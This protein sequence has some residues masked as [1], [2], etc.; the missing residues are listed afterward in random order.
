VATAERAAAPDAFRHEA[1]F[2]AGDDEYLDLAVPFLRE[3]VAREEPVLVVVLAPK[4]GLLRDALGDDAD[5]VTFADMADVGANP[6]RIIPAWRTFVAAHQGRPARGIGEPIFPARG[7]EEL[8]E[9][10]RHEALLNLAFAGA[11]GFELVCPYDTALLPPD[12]VEEALR[13]HPYVHAAGTSP[14]YRDGLLDQPLGPPPAGAARLDYGDGPLDVVHRFVTAYASN[15]GLSP[16]RA[17]D[18]SIAAHELAINTIRHAG[19]RGSVAVWVEGGYV[20]CEVRDDGVI[21][22][23]LVGRALPPVEQESGRGMWMVNQLCDLVQLRSS[24]AGTTVRVRM[25]LA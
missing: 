8:V 5:G 16:S 24:A 23:P 12:V 11:D 1:L 2:Y 18:L 10:Q 15:A 25:A 22:D 17:I 20:V 14:A 9:C 7:P 3:G 19:G 13:S 4:I 21:D 6:A